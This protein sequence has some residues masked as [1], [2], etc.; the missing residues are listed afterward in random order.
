MK[1]GRAEYAVKLQFVKGDSSLS[2]DYIKEEQS[3][4]MCYFPEGSETL[5][6]S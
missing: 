6:F 5:H 1:Q 2:S 4:H 3:T